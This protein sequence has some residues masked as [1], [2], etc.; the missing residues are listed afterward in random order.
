MKGYVEITRKMIEDCLNDEI[1]MMYQDSSELKYPIDHFKK[2]GEYEDFFEEYL[3]NNHIKVIDGK[4]YE[5][6]E[7]YFADM[8]LA[9]DGHPLPDDK[10]EPV[11]FGD[12]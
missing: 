1:E 12:R 8:G 5:P 4:F 9:T 6:N 3:I 7:D 10:F 2:T 11:T